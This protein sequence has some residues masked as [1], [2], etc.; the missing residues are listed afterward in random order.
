MGVNTRVN[1]LTIN[2]MAKENILII[3]VHIKVNLN[4]L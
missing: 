3:P 4:N 1:G 2:N